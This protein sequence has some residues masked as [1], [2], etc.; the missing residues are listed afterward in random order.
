MLC[1]LLS[2]TEWVGARFPTYKYFPIEQEFVEVDPK[3]P[4]VVECYNYG[5]NVTRAFLDDFQGP[6]P[7]TPIHGWKRTAEGEGD[8][9]AVEV[10]RLRIRYLVIVNIPDP[11]TPAEKCLTSVRILNEE[12]AGGAHWFEADSDE[13]EKWM[14]AVKEKFGSDAILKNVVV[15]KTVMKVKTFGQIALDVELDDERMLI[16]V[17]TVREFGGKEHKIDSISRI[18]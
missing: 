18:Y 3:D 10:M 4:I 7:I 11:A 13:K 16:E 2:W 12:A 5:V 1:F 6:H 17:R 9:Y 14:A 8:Y 15:Y